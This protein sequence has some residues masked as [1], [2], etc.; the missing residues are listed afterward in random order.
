M[1]ESATPIVERKSQA[2]PKRDALGKFMIGFAIAL[3][4]LSLAL[5]ALAF[6]VHDRDQ[7]TILVFA[8]VAFVSGIALIA[9]SHP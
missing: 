2:K 6:V 5:F 7:A 1:A 4:V 8:G 9:G 3:L